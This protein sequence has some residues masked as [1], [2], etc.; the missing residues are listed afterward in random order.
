MCSCNNIWSVS[1][2]LIII[3]FT[4]ILDFI[5]LAMNKTTLLD[6]IIAFNSLYMAMLLW[7]YSLFQNN[8]PQVINEEIVMN[9]IVTN[10]LEKKSIDTDR[11]IV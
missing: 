5:S 2:V 1:F 11:T 9:E 8:K 10:N 4:I 6:M 3:I 7:V